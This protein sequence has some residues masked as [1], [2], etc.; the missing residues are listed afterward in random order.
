MD[1]ELK[2]PSLL[3]ADV[4]GTLLD[5]EGLHASAYSDALLKLGGR[6]INYDEYLAIRPEERGS[7]VDYYRA[8]YSDVDAPALRAEKAMSYR[9]RLALDADLYPGVW[10]ILR[11]FSESGRVGLVTSSSQSSVVA[12]CETLLHWL[13]PSVV[14]SRDTGGVRPKP[15][16]EPYQRALSELGASTENTLVIED[17]PEGV[18]SAK[19]AGLRCIAK[20]GRW[21]AEDLA[22]ADEVVDSFSQLLVTH[23]VSGGRIATVAHANR[24]GSVKDAADLL[25]ALIPIDSDRINVVS[26]GG[27]PFSCKTSVTTELVRMRKVESVA[28]PTEAVIKSRSQRAA[29]DLDGCDAM[30]HD[31]GALRR[32]V[33]ELLERHTIR[34][35]T[36]S[37]GSGTISQRQPTNLRTR[38]GSTIVVDGSVA[39]EP[40]VLTIS[41]LGIAFVPVEFR[42]W[43]ASA[44]RRDV[45]ERC[46]VEDDAILMNQ[47]KAVT[48][49]RQVLAALPRLNFVVEVSGDRVEPL[50]S[51]VRASELSDIVYDSLVTLSA[52]QVGDLL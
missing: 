44:V 18:A 27:F 33:A 31:L 45:E 12:L 2:H 28:L 42:G 21:S 1:F 13:D 16:A 4:D 36:Y 50:L 46:W 32:M 20:I 49:A 14:I 37:W 11:A 22:E 8:L 26:I 40:E 3:L 52:G 29:L 9:R 38:G 30:A 24:P 23:Q 35:P 10:A 39:L 34:I 19:A 5:T 25:D 15:S 51:I 47:R 41:N 6:A 17:S 7:P 48:A 43:I